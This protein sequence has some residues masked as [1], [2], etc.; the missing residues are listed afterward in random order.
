MLW[1]F[2]YFLFFI[3]NLSNPFFHWS[4]CLE[5][6]N[7]RC[8]AE[9]SRSWCSR[10]PLWQQV[11]GWFFPTANTYFKQICI[12]F[13]NWDQ[14]ISG[15]CGIVQFISTWPIPSSDLLV[16]K[17][18]GKIWV[19]LPPH[20][21]RYFIAW[22]RTIAQLPRYRFWHFFLVRNKTLMICYF[23]FPNIEYSRI[24]FVNT[25]IC[26]VQQLLTIDL[27]KWCVTQL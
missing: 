18:S 16:A 26:F 6:P 19:S 5:L 3:P 7:R 22:S 8:P 1:F 27:I 12:S 9:Q 20:W 14:M 17:F 4:H 13:Y 24:W 21:T 11:A 25:K 10:P 23:L 2:F 15:N